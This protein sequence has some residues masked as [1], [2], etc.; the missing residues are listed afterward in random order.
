M[1]AALTSVSYLCSL[2]VLGAT[3]PV[4]NGVITLGPSATTPQ[5]AHM[6]Q[7]S[8]CAHPQQTS[9]IFQGKMTYLL[10]FYISYPSTMYKTGLLFLLGFLSYF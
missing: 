1:H 9:G 4:H 8:R 6:L 7:S 10:Y 5:S 2:R 3:C